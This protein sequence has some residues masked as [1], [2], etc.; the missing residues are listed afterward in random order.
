MGARMTEEAGAAPTA[1]GGAAVDELRIGGR[2]GSP[3]VSA[4]AE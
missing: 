3:R 1:E 4:C 2:G